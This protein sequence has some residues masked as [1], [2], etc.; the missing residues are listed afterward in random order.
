[1]T[2]RVR[3]TSAGFDRRLWRPVGLFVA[4]AIG[5]VL[6]RSVSPA[7]GPSFA[8]A[9]ALALAAVWTR[10]RPGLALGAFAV[11]VFAAGWWTV[12]IGRAPAAALLRAIEAQESRPIVAV[13]GVVAERPESRDSA[14]GPF[15]EFAPPGQLTVLRLAGARRGGAGGAP[16]GPRGAFWATVR[17]EAPDALAGDRVRV[18]G[19][20]SPAGRRSN[21]GDPPYR[22]LALQSGAVGFLAV[23]DAGNVEVIERGASP[24]RSVRGWAR[25]RAVAWLPEDRDDTAG[26]LLRAALIGERAEALAPA[27]EAVRRVGVAHLLAVSGLHLTFLVVLGVWSVRAVREPGR[28][29]PLIAAALVIVY[30]VMTPARAP[31]VR[32]ATVALALLAGEASGTRYS[33][34]ALLALAAT[35]TTLWRPMELFSPGFQLSYG[36]VAALVLFQAPV[37]VR[38]FGDPA[39]RG[40]MGAARRWLETG[41]SAALVAWA[42]ATPVLAH[43][44]GIVN[45]LGPIAVLVVA[46][47][48]SATLALG[49]AASAVSLAW[50][51]LGSVVGVAAV[52]GAEVFLAAVLWL[53]RAP[54]MAVYVP[55]VPLAL[56]LISLVVVVWFLWAPRPR[57]LAVGV[58]AA[59]ALAVGVWLADARRSQGLGAG[60]ALRADMLDVADGTMLLLRAGGDAALWDAGSRRLTFGRRDAPAS[61][62]ELGAWGVS[63]VFLTHANLDHYSALPDLARPLGVRTLVTTRYVAEEAARDPEG[64]PARLL[65]MLSE[66]GVG[67]TEAGAGEALLLGGHRVEFLRPPAGL[68]GDNSN[69]TSLVAR[70]VVTTRDVERSLL[71]TGDIEPDGVAALLAAHPGL[72]ADALELPHHGSARLAGEGFVGTLG[73]EVVLQSSG[74]SRLGDERWDRE[75]QGRAWLMTAERGAAWVEILT[76]GSLRWGATRP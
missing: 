47:L 67:F 4:V 44:A 5:I 25:D 30:L 14:R 19:R 23:P 16:V 3:A 9:S 26:A 58:A 35:A 38:L 69:S 34:I 70:I 33:R 63:R 29:E 40:G 52:A 39:L 68:P 24:L 46:P 31:I 71:L 73:P 11:V 75:K 62:R 15:A 6:G 21:P 74:R 12:R 37:R 8:A 48:F 51:W 17:G 55:R 20:V 22:E 53:E 41:V 50:P 65:A 57:R 66:E 28:A 1:M 59:V 56:T 64:A 7:P 13:E 42:V 2:A 43:H 27:D 72:R 10:G 18:W 49:F 32:A 36:C 45:P 61:I 76:D 54:M 60:V